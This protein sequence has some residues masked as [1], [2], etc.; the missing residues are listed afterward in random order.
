MPLNWCE[1]TRS[2]VKHVT[3]RLYP[4][5]AEHFGVT[6]TSVERT[7]RY[8]ISCCWEK[9]N[10]RLLNTIAGRE[11]YERPYTREFVAMVADFVD[12]EGAMAS[13]RS[14]PMDRDDAA[15]LGKLL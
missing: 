7:I 15:Q 9:G 2:L 14:M 3:T 10:R 8:A 5:V 13:L 6:A 1:K 11:L 12:D 4:Q